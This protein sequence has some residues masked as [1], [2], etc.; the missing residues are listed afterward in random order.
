MDMLALGQ[1]D[2]TI[3]DG[4]IVDCAFRRHIPSATGPV[5]REVEAVLARYLRGS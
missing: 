5:D 3:R 2:L 1:L 4:Q